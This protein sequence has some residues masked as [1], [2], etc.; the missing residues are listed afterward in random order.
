MKGKKRKK[1]I[2]RTRPV[3][4]TITLT[5]DEGPSTYKWIGG[6]PRKQKIPPTELELTARQIGGLLLHIDRTR[7]CINGL[8]QDLKNERETLANLMLS[9]QAAV[10]KSKDLALIPQP[11]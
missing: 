8:E 4:S 9:H 11:L 1:K 5:A 2:K 7:R 10:S 3:E 6:S